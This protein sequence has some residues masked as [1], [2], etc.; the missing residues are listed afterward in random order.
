MFVEFL[1][2]LVCILPMFEEYIIFVRCKK[3]LRTNTIGDHGM[4][5]FFEA[6]ITEICHVDCVLFPFL[7]LN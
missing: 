3:F 6:H 4:E 5:C 7:K 2:V 1:V